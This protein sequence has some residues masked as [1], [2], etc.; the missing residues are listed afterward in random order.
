MASI[1]GKMENNL[2]KAQPPNDAGKTAAGTTPAV[3]SSPSV[4]YVP[5]PL[6]LV[7]S[8]ASELSDA[9][10]KGEPQT[11]VVTVKKDSKNPNVVILETKFFGTW[12]G[13]W[14]KGAIRSIEKNYNAIKHNTLRRAAEERMKKDVAQ[15]TGVKGV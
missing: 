3:A 4:L 12:T 10:S 9:L 6:P 1:E 7:F 8:K 2:S 5:T 15:R 13:N 14:I 11:L